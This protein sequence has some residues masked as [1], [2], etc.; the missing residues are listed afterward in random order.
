[1]KI[2]TESGGIIPVDDLE[3]D[4]FVIRSLL[5]Y[6]KRVCCGLETTSKYSP[7]FKSA[8]EYLDRY[9]HALE[10]SLRLIEEQLSHNRKA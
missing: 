1:M 7:E 8:V 6:H 10:T 5:N 9:K 3:F 4:A 2:K